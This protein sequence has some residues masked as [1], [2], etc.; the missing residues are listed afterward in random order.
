MKGNGFEGVG[1]DGSMEEAAKVFG[2]ED[3]K[4]RGEWVS[5]SYATGGAKG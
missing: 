4:E 5:L 2:H 3:K 1:G